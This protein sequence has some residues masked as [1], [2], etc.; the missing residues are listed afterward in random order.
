MSELDTWLRP[1]LEKRSTDAI[2]VLLDLLDAGI[3]RGKCSAL[4]VRE[5]EYEQPNV[6]GGVFKMLPKF[7]FI[8]TDERVKS[9]AKR[10]HARRVDVWKL[11]DARLAV[12]A[13]CKM[14]GVVIERTCNERK[15][16]Q[17]TL[18]F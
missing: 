8:H 9:T 16:M 18:Q 10:K 5:R 7:G 12:D 14:L 6:I 1:M 17:T 4:D 3:A 13:K 2:R 11:P 15:K